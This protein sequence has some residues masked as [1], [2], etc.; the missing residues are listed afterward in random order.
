M[1]ARDPPRVSDAA[2]LALHWFF[3]CFSDS[4]PWGLFAEIKHITIA[5]VGCN[6]EVQRQTESRN[7]QM[8]QDTPFQL[9]KMNVKACLPSLPRSDAQVFPQRLLPRHICADA[10][11]T[12]DACFCG[13]LDVVQHTNVLLLKL[14]EV[15]VKFFM[16]WVED[17]D[18]KA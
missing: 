6:A 10:P 7:S 1:P 16:P 14:L 13:V 18:L 5:D 2:T 8:L 15:L 17:E 3:K 12:L 11:V 9:Q 4:I